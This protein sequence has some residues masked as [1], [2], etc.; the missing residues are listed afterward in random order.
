MPHRLRTGCCRQW[1]SLAAHSSL[2]SARQAGRT[3]VRPIRCSTTM[4]SRLTPATDAAGRCAKKGFPALPWPST[5]TV[6]WSA[7][8]R[9]YRRSPPRRDCPTPRATAGRAAPDA[10]RTG[11]RRRRWP[12][13]GAEIAAARDNSVSARN[14]RSLRCPVARSCYWCRSRRTGICRP[15][16]CNRSLTRHAPQRRRAGLRPRYPQAR[17]YVAERLDVS[18]QR[19][20]W[21]WAEVKIK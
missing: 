17:R 12:T 11:V 20:T 3:A 21:Y 13:A 9:A 16:P 5:N 10:A 4:Y 1:K 19:S 7:A 6:P 14:F 2:H 18:Y 8:A 15:G